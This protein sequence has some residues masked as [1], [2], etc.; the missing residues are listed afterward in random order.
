MAIPADIERKR[1]FMVE[2]VQ[3]SELDPAVKEETIQNLVSTAASTNGLTGDEKIQAISIN[4]FDMARSDARI[5]L[6]MSAGFKR[7]EERIEALAPTGFWPALFRLL[8]TCRWQLCI[9]AAIVAG[10]LIIKP[11]LAAYL[12]LLRR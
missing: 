7:I 3:A 9:I 1:D 11:E 2:Q 5:H 6:S 8:E 10:M 4:Q 12:E